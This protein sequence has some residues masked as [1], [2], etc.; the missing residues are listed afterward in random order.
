MSERMNEMEMK[1]NKWN[2][3]EWKEGK[4]REGINEGINECI[5]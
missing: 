3:L 2:G 4:E 1:W 5:N